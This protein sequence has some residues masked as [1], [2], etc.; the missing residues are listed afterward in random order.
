MIVLVT[1]EAGLRK[2]SHPKTKGLNLGIVNIVVPTINI[3]N[4]LHTGKLVKTVARKII[5][6]KSADQKARARAIQVQEAKSHL[7]REVTVDQESSDDGQ[8]DEI[9]AFN[10]DA[11]VIQICIRLYGIYICICLRCLSSNA[12]KMYGD[13]P[14]TLRIMYSKYCVWEINYIELTDFAMFPVLN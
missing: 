3:N 10:F 6:L 2:N 12:I 11:K 7:N 14:E 13:Q 9:L 4:A 8:I 5:L 1:K